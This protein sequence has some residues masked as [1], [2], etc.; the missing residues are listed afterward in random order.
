MLLI[1]YIFFSIFIYLSSIHQFTSLPID[2]PFCLGLFL[3]SPIFEV[4]LVQNIPCFRSWSA[5]SLPFFQ[6]TTVWPRVI[7]SIGRQVG[8]QIVMVCLRLNPIIDG[9]VSAFQ[10]II[11]TS[12]VFKAPDGRVESIIVYGYMIDMAV[13]LFFHFTH[14]KSADHFQ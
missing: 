10:K 12:C 1:Y 5:L 14:P 7:A 8:A 9:T 11:R 2:S 4:C 13:F 6:S 3:C